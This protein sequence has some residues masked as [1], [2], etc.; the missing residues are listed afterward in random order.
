MLQW[1]DYWRGRKS[2][3]NPHVNFTEVERGSSTPDPVG[4]D[5]SLWG[6]LNIFSALFVGISPN[7]NEGGLYV[8]LMEE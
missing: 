1:P 2:Q 6:T 4:K 7:V 8:S 5:E 3:K